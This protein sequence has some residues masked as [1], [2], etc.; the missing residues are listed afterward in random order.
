M[1]RQCQQIKHSLIFPYCHDRKSESRVSLFSLIIKSGQGYRVW[2]G[3]ART[4]E[5]LLRDRQWKTSELLSWPGG[6]EVEGAAPPTLKGADK[7]LCLHR[8][9]THL[10]AFC[11]TQWES[12]AHSNTFSVH[13]DSFWDFSFHWR[14][15]SLKFTLL[16]SIKVYHFM[17]KDLL[18]KKRS[19]LLKPL[20][21]I[22]TH[23]TLKQRLWL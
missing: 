1:N 16:L 22:L 14:H 13:P 5:A 12:H 7:L 11:E 21:H 23:Y 6:C 19:R 3:T 15:H 9:R 2:V 18:L 4:Q 20:F 17:G 10:L 8:T